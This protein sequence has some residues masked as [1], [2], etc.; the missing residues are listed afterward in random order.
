MI[1][2]VVTFILI[3]TVSFVGVYAQNKKTKENEINPIEVSISGKIFNLSSDT[4]FLGKS[5]GDNQLKVYHIDSVDDEGAF[6]FKVKLPH[7]DYYV[8]RVADGQTINLVLRDKD[9]IE[10]YG[11]GKQLYQHLNIVGSE[12][13]EELNKFIRQ[14]LAYVA[15]LDSAR[16]YLKENQDKAREVNADFKPV[17]TGFINMRR[18]FINRN[19]QSPA[20]IAAINSLNTEDE[21]EIYEDVVKSLEKSFG[22]SPTVQSLVVQ[23]EQNRKEFLANQPLSPGSKASEIAMENPDGEIMKLSDYEGKVVLLDF[24]ASWCGPCRKE[25]PTVVKLYNKYK[26]DGFEVFS[27]SLDKDRKRWVDAIEKDNLVWEAHVSDLKGWKN[28]AAQQYQVSGIP[29]TVLLDKEGK[30]INTK[31]RGVQLE[32]TLESIFGY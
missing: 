21:F 25:N 31:L 10:I 11:D 20:L 7:P 17:H 13:S 26:D 29:F 2:L 16:E 14:N 24:W 12:D 18:N 5:I 6:S 23:L 30:V 8:L 19:K 4:L 32:M 15:K 22:E 3:G 9:D 1:R 28:E 27:V